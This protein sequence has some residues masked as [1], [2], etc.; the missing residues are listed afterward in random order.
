MKRLSATLVLLAAACAPARPGAAPAPGAG[1]GTAEGTMPHLPAIPL[2]TGPLE[3]K[4]VHPAP[5][6]ALGVRDSTFVFG[7]TGTGE[8]RLW[9]DGRP[10]P[11]QPNGAF[12]AYLPVPPAGRYHLVATAGADTSQLEL[13]VVLPPPLPTFPPDTAVILAGSIT[14]RG[15]WTALPGERIEVGFRGAPGGRASL[16]LPSG[17]RVPLVETPLTVHPTPQAETFMTTPGAAAAA[18]VHG[19]SSYRGYFGAEPLAAAASTIPQPTL[20]ASQATPGQ[21]ATLELVVG[22]DT[23]RAPLPLNLALANPERPVVAAAVAPPPPTGGGVVV[24]RPG[25]GFTYAY[26]WPDAT[27]L[28]L[29]GERN[30]EYRVRLTPELDAWVARDQVRRLPAGTSPPGG[31]VGTLRLTPAPGYVDLRIALPDRLPFQVTEG[32]RTLEVTIFGGV[33]DTD[34]LLYGPTDPLIH[35]ADWR[36][37]A[38]GTYQAVLHLEERPWGYQTFWA[39][40]GDLILRVRRPPALDPDHP[41]RG[42][43]I[44]I[45]AGHPPAGATGP[46]GLTEAEANLA[47][48]LRLLPL[49]ERAGARVLMTRTDMTP[50]GLAERTNMATEANADLLVSI[51]N[52]ALPE[53][54]NPFRN[55]GTSVY[56]NHPQSL[57]LARALQQSLLEEFGLRDL[58]VGR[59][60]LALVRPTWMPAV[61]TESFFMMIPQQ[62]AALRDPAVQERLARAHLRGIESFLREYPR[63]ARREAR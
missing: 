2:R 47:I 60:D 44:A 57:E 33:A 36:Q 18:P 51:H 32:E 55:N 52:N 4:I 40:N 63:V 49:L 20:V 53:G 5:G 43:L 54:V 17:R 26:F 21:A 31:A 12:L 11:V 58:G 41:L 3:L 6:A 29:T 1:P 25:P 37:P 16:I 45:D 8:A 9:I 56:Y 27:R 62:E 59:A 42:L 46:T 39:Q 34:W 30:G 35:R 13:E 19:L 14:P 15:G 38:T 22:D 61:L 7:S 28:A 50:L 48:A 24:G 10:V 23:A